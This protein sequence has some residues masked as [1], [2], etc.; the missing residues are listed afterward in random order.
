MMI[1]A[2]PAAAGEHCARCGACRNL[3][4]V[5]RAVPEVEEIE[6]ICW[7]VK[8]EDFCVPGPSKRCG[9]VHECDQCGPW[10]RTI[11]QPTC[12][13]VRTRKVPVKTVVKRKIPKVKWVVETVCADCCHAC[14]G[15]YSELTPAQKLLA[16]LDSFTFGARNAD[17]VDAPSVPS[18][19]N[20]PTVAGSSA[21]ARP[22]APTIQRGVAQASMAAVP[23]G[24]PSAGANGATGSATAFRSFVD[25]L[26]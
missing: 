15:V 7:S 10:C 5:C 3:K 11:W 18:P 25:R 4:K 8:C 9:I 19:A 14:A 12:A 17:A 2:I 23:A 26:R 20:L 24:Q 16:R 22:A 21:A 13:C 1:G 6:Q